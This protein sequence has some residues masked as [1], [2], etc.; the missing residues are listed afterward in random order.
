MP[1]STLPIASSKECW[2][3]RICR[4]RRWMSRLRPFSGIM[5][6]GSSCWT[7]RSRIS[8]QKRHPDLTRTRSIRGKISGAANG[9]MLRGDIIRGSIRRGSI[10]RGHI[11]GTPIR[12]IR[13]TTAIRIITG[14]R[15][16]TAET[17]AGA[18]TSSRSI[19]I[20]SRHRPNRTT[21][22]LQATGRR[23]RRGPRR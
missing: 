3:R 4:S 14:G 5:R 19:R 17:T 22:I 21:R 2:R 16:R 23:R 20:S 9:T 6:A 18:I 8:R 7:M 11:S 13:T 12:T 10:T 1:K 15:I